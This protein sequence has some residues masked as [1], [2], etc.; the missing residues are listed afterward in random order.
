ML[1]ETQDWDNE[2]AESCERDLSGVIVEHESVAWQRWNISQSV[3]IRSL[4]V[5]HPHSPPAAH[6][7]VWRC[8][9]CRSSCQSQTP[10]RGRWRAWCWRCPPPSHSPGRCRASPWQW[11][12]S[13]PWSSRE[14]WEQTSRVQYWDE[15]KYFWVC[16]IWVNLNGCHNT[17]SK[18]S[19]LEQPG[20]D[21][22]KSICIENLNKGFQHFWIFTARSKIETKCENIWDE[23]CIVVPQCCPPTHTECW[24]LGSWPP[25]SPSCW[26]WSERGS[27]ASPGPCCPSPPGPRCGWSWAACWHCTRTCHC[28]PG[29]SCWWSASSHQH[30]SEVWKQD[31]VS[32][33]S[34]S[35]HLVIFKFL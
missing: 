34:I 15:R 9:R 3:S 18:H 22:F 19:S 23:T 13:P 8:L 25:T 12:L 6:W 32:C 14:S 21:L 31:H 30:W 5:T 7:Q 17:C 16:M 10:S 24:D 4:S 33:S 35:G 2:D 20:V 28:P 11:T 26:C 27:P 1:S 29:W